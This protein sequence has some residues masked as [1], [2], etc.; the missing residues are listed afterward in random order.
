MSIQPADL[1]AAAESMVRTLSGVS[2]GQLSD[3]TPCSEWTVADLLLHIQ[4]FTVVF[5]ANARK[6]DAD[7]PS[8]LSGDWG[9][10]MT[11]QIAELVAAWQQPDAWEGM[12]E[13]GGIEMPAADNALVAAEE[14]TVHAWDLAKATG[15]AYEPSDAQVDVV[16]RFL[17]T[18]ADPDRPDEG[19]FGPIH[20]APSDASRWERALARTGRDPRGG[21]GGVSAGSRGRA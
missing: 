3:P 6:R 11:E 19:P 5:T 18:F 2:D 15:L 21:R 20:P 13:A 12:T 9:R 4:Q 16:E 7:P 8:Q 14:L 10:E 17:A 1:S